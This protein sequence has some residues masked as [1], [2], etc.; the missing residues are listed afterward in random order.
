MPLHCPSTCKQQRH[1]DSEGKN[2]KKFTKC[3][4]ANSICPFPK[5][6][7]NGELMLAGCPQGTERTV[8]KQLVQFETFLHSILHKCSSH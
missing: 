8:G 4:C 1:H 3:K 7:A 6:A 2:Q 5:M